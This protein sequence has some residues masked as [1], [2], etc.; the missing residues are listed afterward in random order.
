MFS[1][2]FSLSFTAICRSYVPIYAWIPCFIVIQSPICAKSIAK[3]NWL[4]ASDMC[5]L[6]IA[7]N[8]KSTETPPTSNHL[9]TQTHNHTRTH[10]H[11]EA[12]AVY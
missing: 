5:K 6:A 1:F 3:S 9:H 11:T 4:A 8:V 7:T 2:S 12:T 10:T